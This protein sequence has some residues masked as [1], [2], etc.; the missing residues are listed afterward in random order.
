[1]LII[2]LLLLLVLFP[3][4]FAALSSSNTS[5]PS[6]SRTVFAYYYGWYTR[7]SWYSAGTSL[8]SAFVPSL[9]LYNSSN[10]KII[11]SQIGEASSAGIN[12]FIASWWGPNSQTDNTD[13]ILLDEAARWDGFSV[14]LF[15]ETE[16]LQEMNSSYQMKQAKVVSDV[17]YIMRYYGS[18][19]AFAETNGKPVLFF[20]NVDNWP[21][22]F[23]VSIASAVHAQYPSLQLIGNSFNPSYLQAFDGEASYVD[24]GFAAEPNSVV[25]GTYPT[26]QMISD[27]A[28][29]SGKLWFATAS[30]GFNG[31]NDGKTNFPVVPRNGGSTFLE[32]WRIAQNSHPDG[33]IVGTWNEY[34]EGTSIE[35]TSS[36]GDY[37]L[38]LT[39]QEAM[40]WRQPFFLESAPFSRPLVGDH[41]VQLSGVPL[42]T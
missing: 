37:Y 26:F 21:L 34:F 1:M 22:Q 42:A 36:Y 11:D 35:P 12:G 14:T 13:R 31:T 15:Y 41:V 32:S 7:G 25:D 29:A 5:A 39:A 10:V 8:S 38:Q 40:A 9:G 3:T 30:P 17:S 24:L 33:I 28:H 18:S 6:S 27:A 20:Y 2:A 19:S 16:I 4:F 23:W